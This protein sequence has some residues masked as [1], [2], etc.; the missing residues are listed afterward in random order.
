MYLSLL[1]GMTQLNQSTVSQCRRKAGRVTA[2]VCPVIYL[3]VI[4]LLDG[5]GACVTG[6]CYLQ[7]VRQLQ[8][9]KDTTNEGVI[10]SPAYPLILIL[11]SCYL[12]CHA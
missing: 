5:N 3:H 7:F 8:S 6:N 10:F 12:Q 2:A 9:T 1:H 4:K 11:F